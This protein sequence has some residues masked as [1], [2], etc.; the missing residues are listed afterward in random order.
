M[1]I[2]FQVLIIVFLLVASAYAGYYIGTKSSG[3]KPEVV[4]RTVTK[5]ERVKLPFPT[6]R[7]KGKPQYSD[8]ILYKDA[9]GYNFYY[10]RNWFV[11]KGGYQVQSWDPQR[12]NVRPRPL[13]NEESKWDLNFEKQ[14]L[15]SFEKELTQE[16]DSIT[17]WDL[18]EISFTSK[19][20]PVYFAYSNVPGEVRGGPYLIAGIVTPENEVVTWHGYSGDS[21]SPNIEVLKQIAESVYKL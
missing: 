18:F 19:G 2:I 20:W 7:I 14:S 4:T 16:D 15:A 6:A 17:K 9:S 11:S 8:W 21:K 12:P 10:P 3:K 1:K 5:V 13:I